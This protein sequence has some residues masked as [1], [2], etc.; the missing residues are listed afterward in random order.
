MSGEEEEKP[1]AEYAVGYC[2]PPV[3]HRF[4]KGCSGNPRGRAKGRKRGNAS[5]NAS[6][7]RLKVIIL[8]EAYRLISVKD[9]NGPI[10]LSTAQAVVRSLAINAAKG[11]LR[12]QRLFTELL[13]ETEQTNRKRHI[14]WLETVIQ[15]KVSWER[16]LERRERLGI[17]GPE[18]LPHPD[19]IVVDVRADTVS[20]NGPATKEEKALW[21]KMDARKAEC[22]ASIAEYREMLEDESDPKICARIEDD[23][24][25]EN[26]LE[27]LSLR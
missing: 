20:V 4:R 19:D 9:A 25:H 17:T 10:T 27:I 14:E 3:E 2:K 22:D 24:Q 26:A 18:P 7:E 16:E 23:I 6:E 8:E 12:A 15:Y 1:R 5:V 11:N 13:A 21:D